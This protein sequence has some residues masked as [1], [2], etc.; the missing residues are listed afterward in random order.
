M[1]LGLGFSG[2]LSKPAHPKAQASDVDDLVSFG[3]S[4]RS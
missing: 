4:Q 1:L 3:P 2:A